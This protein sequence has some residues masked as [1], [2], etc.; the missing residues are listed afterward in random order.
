MESESTQGIGRVPKNLTGRSALCV[1]TAIPFLTHAGEDIEDRP[2]ENLGQIVMA[3][4]PTHAFHRL[5]ILKGTQ[6]RPSGKRLPKPLCQLL[7]IRS[8]LEFTF[9]RLGRLLPEF[10]V[11]QANNQCAQVAK[12]LVEGV[13]FDRGTGIESR[14]NPIEQ[15]MTEFMRDNMNRSA[16]VFD[17]ALS[18]LV[19]IEL[20]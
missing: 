5:L 19:V 14:A 2:G 13:R 15:C 17:L 8:V 12:K 3:C 7:K 20:Q 9:A 11:L 16:S 4:R 10:L 18:I 6:I 1:F